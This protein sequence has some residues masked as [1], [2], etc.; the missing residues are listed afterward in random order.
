[1]V[2][3]VLPAGEANAIKSRWIALGAETAISRQHPP[4][5]YATP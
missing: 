5:G 2:D 4:Y 3:F 1:M